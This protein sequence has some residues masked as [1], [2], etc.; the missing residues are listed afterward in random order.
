MTW[1]KKL[2]CLRP[3]V[4]IRKPLKTRFARLLRA[5]STSPTIY[6]KIPPIF[7]FLHYPKFLTQFN[8]LIVVRMSGKKY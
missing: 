6:Y 4:K 3:H 7:L 1:K 8:Y 2:A 5:Q